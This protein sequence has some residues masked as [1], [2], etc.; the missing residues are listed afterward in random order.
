VDID[1]VNILSCPASLQLEAR[2]TDESFPE[3]GD[4][5]VTIVPES[6]TGPYEYTWNTG[7]TTKTISNLSAGAYQVTVTDR[8]GC[9]DAA[10]VDVGLITSLDR[11][12]QVSALRLMPNPTTG[13]SLLDVSLKEP[14]EVQVQ[15]LSTMGQ[16]LYE[17]QSRRDSRVQFNI[18]LSRYPAGMYLLR[19][20]AGDQLLTRKLMRTE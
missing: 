5:A 2:V 13:I 3:A 17:T 1:N 9:T 20:R 12:D 15:V 19:I 14:V 8:F 16:L 4:G 11:V 7:D 18:D 6:S 10:S